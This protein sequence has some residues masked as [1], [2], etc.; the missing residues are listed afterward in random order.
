MAWTEISGSKNQEEEK[1]IVPLTITPCDPLGTFLLPV[2]AALSTAGLGVLVSEEGALLAR[3]HTNIELKLRL[4][5]W[6]LWV[7]DA[8]KPTD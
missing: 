8:L 2:P 5:P 7:S 6:P 1:R 4:P 3:R